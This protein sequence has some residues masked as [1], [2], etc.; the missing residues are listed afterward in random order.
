VNVRAAQ[1]RDFEAVTTLLEELGREHVTP[2]TREAA[3]AVFTAQIEDPE[4]CPLVVED[5]TGIVVACCSLHF[6]P[7]LNRPT[8]DAWIPDLI[9]TAAARRRGAARALLDEAERRARDRG[10]W[11]LTLESGHQRK[12]AHVLY[13]AFGMSQEGYYFSK[14]LTEH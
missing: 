12:E 11:Q 2:D 7:R 4:A 3:H 9:V 14:Q 10:C 1:P 8:P 13:E 5:T 6:R